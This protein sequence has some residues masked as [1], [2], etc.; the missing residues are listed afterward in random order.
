M[1]DETQSKPMVTTPEGRLINNSVFTKDIY[2]DPT[3]G[4][5]GV[6][7][8]KIEM[9]FEEGVLEKIDEE[10]AQAAKAKWG[11]GAYDEYFDAKIRSPILDGDELVKRREDRGKA[12]DAYAGMD[13]IR[14]HTQFNQFGA[15]ALGGIAVFGPD[16]KPIEPAAQQDIYN[17]CYGC[18]RLTIDSYI[19]SNTQRRALMFYLNAFQKTRDGD[20]LVAQQDHAGAF[21]P[22]GRPEGESTKRRRARG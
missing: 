3:T 9:A 22:V 17:G 10:L 21:K 1:T 20:R 7:S 15:D 13:V 18:A 6:P 14:A 2:K 8:Y 5:E 19:E 11:A 12:G 16:V 4:K